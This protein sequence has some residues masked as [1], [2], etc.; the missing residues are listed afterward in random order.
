[1]SRRPN[2]IANIGQDRQGFGA[3][4]G[5]LASNAL[6]R[7]TITPAVDHHRCTRRGECPRNG[8]TD[9]AARA[10]DEG[11]APLQFGADAHGLLPQFC[12]FVRLPADHPRACLSVGKAIN[13]V[14]SIAG[15]SCN[16][17]PTARRS[18]C[19]RFD[20]HLARKARTGTSGYWQT[21]G[22]RATH[23]ADGPAPTVGDKGSV[24]GCVWLRGRPI[25]WRIGVI[26]PGPSDR[27]GLMR[28]SCGSVL[29]ILPM[30]GTRAPAPGLFDVS[31]PVRW[32]STGHGRAPA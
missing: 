23:L 17:I 14:T 11:N 22:S 5:D 1:M 13:L 27:S 28:L 31:E 29:L 32:R 24:R 30:H 8:S 26:I 19:G 15:S 4:A 10:G 20:T 16:G 12:P 9:I 18:T 25:P 2:L 21:A 7:V 6:D 3:E